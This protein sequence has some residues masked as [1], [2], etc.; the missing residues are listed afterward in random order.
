MS[1]AVPEDAPS[2][3][4]VDD[5]EAFARALGRALGKRGFAVD[6]A[7]DAEQARQKAAA[8]PPDYAVVDL[9]MPGD[10]GLTVVQD[11]MEGDPEARVVVLTGYASITTAVEAVKL[12]ATQYLSKPAEADDVVRALMQDEPDPNIPIAEQTLSVDRLEWEHLQ[13]VLAESDGNI[14]E[15]ARRLGMHR[16]TLQRKLKKRPVHR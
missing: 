2:L 5:D 8:E 4:L 10:S 14:S 13:R 11:L 16:R 12:G 15:A 7:A 6:T 9:K 1:E 3:L